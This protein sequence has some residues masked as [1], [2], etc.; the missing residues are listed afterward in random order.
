MKTYHSQAVK[1]KQTRLA[2]ASVAVAALVIVGLSVFFAVMANRNSIKADAPVVDVAKPVEQ[3]SIPVA[4]YTVAASPSIDKLVYMSSL[5]LWK[6]HNGV[7]LAAKEGSAVTAAYSGK[8][9]KVEQSTLDGIV[10]TIVQND[11]LTAIY[12]SLSS[13]SV[14]EGDLV[15]NGDT[16]GVV[17]TMLSESDLGTHL[18]FELKK[19]GK[20]VDPLSYLDMTGTDK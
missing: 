13:A 1:K 11:G 2:I 17:G 8:V 6:T 12:R 19:D 20:Y 9:S 18:H 15:A 4:D 3:Y 14:K 5:N 10:V 7:D 16:V